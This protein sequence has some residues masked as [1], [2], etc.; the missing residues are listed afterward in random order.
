MNVVVEPLP[1]CLAT[2]RVEVDPAKVSETRDAVAKEFGQFARI[3]GYRPGKAPRAVIERKY[4]KQIAEELEKKL[5]SESTRQAI[6]EQKLR[7]LQLANVEDVQISDDNKM[8]FTA[9]VVTQPQFDVPN[10]KGIEINLPSTEVTE[11]EIDESIENLR[12]QAADFTDLEED[13]GAKMDDFIVVNYS[14]T[15]DGKPV[16]EV[17]P[18][19]GKP[20][21]GNDDFWIKMTDEA[22]FPGFCAALVDAKPGETRNFDVEVPADFPVEGMGGQKISYEVKLNA[23]KVKQL[24]ELNDEFADSV[25]KGKTMAELREMA[26]EELGRQKTTNAEGEKRNQVMKHLLSQVECELPQNMVRHE[27]Q[28][29]L[30]DIVRENQTRG[31]SEEVLRENQKE[32]MGAASQNARERLKGTFIL[33]RIAEAEGIKVNKEEIFGRIATMAQ[34]YE[35]PFEKMLKELEKRN[36]LDEINEEILSGKV[37]DFLISNASV[38]NEPA[39]TAAAS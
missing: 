31:V 30:A 32:L 38:K 20:L 27:T 13:R 39:A 9:T 29:I 34:R 18:K 5:I 11:A 1:N 17:F 35:M 16:H 15:I 10:Y 6:A 19:A 21:S 36:A 22:F 37:L 8:S 25:V 4:K 3:P 12:E 2:L 26:R 7:V 33:V 14:G 28:R 23:I 24:P